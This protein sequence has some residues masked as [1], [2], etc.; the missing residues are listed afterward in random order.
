[1]DTE[2]LAPLIPAGHSYFHCLLSTSIHH[3]LPLPPFLPLYLFLSFFSLSRPA[4]KLSSSAPFLSLAT[5]PF[6]VAAHASD[7]LAV[8]HA[9]QERQAPPAAAAS[10]STPASV[11]SAPASAS[12]SAPAGSAVVSGSAAS[13]VSALSSSAIPLPATT[14]TFSLQ[15]TNPTAVPLSDIVAT[16]AT[17]ATLPLDSTAAPGSTPTYLPGAP[18]L[19]DGTYISSHPLP[20]F[21]FVTLPSFFFFFSPA[22]F[23]L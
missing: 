13:G 21:A 20:V 1:M 23:T 9:H 10:A 7:P 6:L 2:M 14:F 16:A 12:V 4:M 19:P 17:S 8:R 22:I 18:P 5:I 3:L 15:A 11:S